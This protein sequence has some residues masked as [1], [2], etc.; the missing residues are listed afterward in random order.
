MTHLKS[1]SEEKAAENECFKNNSFVSLIFFFS[2]CL[3]VTCNQNL[4]LNKFKSF[5]NKCESFKLL[6]L[7]GNSM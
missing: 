7:T 5:F 1:D 4:C 2:V 6:L 3:R